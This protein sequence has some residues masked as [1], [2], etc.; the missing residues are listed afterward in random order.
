MLCS[1]WKP[2]RVSSPSE[3]AGRVYKPFT[4]GFGPHGTLDG[5]GVELEATILDALDLD[6]L[7]LAL[8][9]ISR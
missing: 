7:R 4:Y 3:W 5:V 8:T 9:S 2:V 1:N 6:A